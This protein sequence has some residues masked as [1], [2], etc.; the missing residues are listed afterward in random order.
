MKACDKQTWKLKPEVKFQH[1]VSLLSENGS[2]NIS[3]AD[4]RTSP[5]FGLQVDFGLPN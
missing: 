4:K 3:A 2:S 5:K 1:G